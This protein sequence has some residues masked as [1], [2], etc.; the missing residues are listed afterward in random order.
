MTLEF[1]HSNDMDRT[2]GSDFILL[3]LLDFNKNLN[4]KTSSQAS[5]LLSCKEINTPQ[6]IDDCLTPP[7]TV[8]SNEF[9][10]SRVHKKFHLFI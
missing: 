3:F 2:K 8:Q 4:S 6:S 5:K 10:G 7:E 9:S 1:Y